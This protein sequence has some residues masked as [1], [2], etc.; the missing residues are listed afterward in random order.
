[1]QY[2]KLYNIF[3][4]RVLL[5]TQIVRLQ[6]L[7]SVWRA[8]SPS[9]LCKRKMNVISFV[10]VQ[11]SD[12]HTSK[13]INKPSWLRYLSS[14]CFCTNQMPSVS[15]SHPAF[16]FPEFGPTQARALPQ[17]NTQIHTIQMPIPLQQ[18]KDQQMRHPEIMFGTKRSMKDSRE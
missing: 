10:T 17:M 5:I 14:A 2:K 1:M 3:L 16:S 15:C 11:I 9:S 7:L 13:Q 12:L 6:E 4:L 18:T 8:P